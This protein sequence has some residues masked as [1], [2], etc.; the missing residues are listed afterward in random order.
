[1]QDLVYKIFN[2]DSIMRKMFNGRILYKITS[3]N[4]IKTSLENVQ[5]AK[6]T[7]EVRLWHRCFPVNFAKFLR[8]P[9]L[10]NTSGC[11]FCRQC[12]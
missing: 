1:M 4:K 6:F 3:K 8:T 12:Y 7:Q 5:Y 9:F 10:T 2:L 11:Y